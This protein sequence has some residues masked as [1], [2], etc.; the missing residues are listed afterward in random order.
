MPLLMVFSSIRRT[1]LIGGPVGLYF[2]FVLG[3][4]VS[5]IERV[6]ERQQQRLT[7]ANRSGS[8]DLVYFL[9]AFFGGRRDGAQSCHKELRSHVSER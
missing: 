5:W 4:E 8:Q 1:Y 9:P 6:L 2:A 7:A 3:S